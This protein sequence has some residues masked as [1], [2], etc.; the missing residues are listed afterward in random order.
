MSPVR[1]YLLWARPY[2]PM[3]GV[4]ITL[5]II[6]FVQPL[7]N[8]WLTKIIVDEV[9]KGA[10]SWGLYEVVTLMAVITVCGIAI[11]FIRG[12][13]TAGLGNR[14]MRDLRDQLYDHLQR[15]SVGF[16]EQRHVGG[17]SSRILHDIGGAQ[18]L[19]GGGVINLVMDLF[20]VLFAG[21]M[22]F[23][24]DATLAFIAL[25]ILPLYYLSFTNLNVRIRLAWRSVHRQMERISGTLV[26]RMS[27]I[28]VVQAFNGEKIEKHRFNKQTQQHFQHTMSAHLVSNLLGRMSETLANA[29]SIV[30]WLVG[31][32]FAL[33][34][35]MTAGEI[36]AFQM[37]LGNLYGPIQRFADVNVTIQNSVTNIERIFELFD[38][39]PDVQSSPDARPMPVCRGQVR[40]QDVS[41]KYV[42]RTPVPQHAVNWKDPD[43]VER[44]A[45][46]KKFF[47][48]PTNVNPPKPVIELEEREAMHDISFEA[49]PGQVIALVGP[50]GAGK[51][52]LI[53]FI[54][55]FYD[56]EKGR[57]FID[58]VDVRDYVLED[59]RRHIAIVLQDNILFSGSIRD[60]LVYGRPD[61]TAAEIVAAARSANAHEFIESFK[62][63]YDSI[64]GERGMRLSGGQKQRLAI[65]RA[66]LKD[67]QILIL[68]EATS[69][70]DSE[71]EA[72]VTE[73]L[74]RLM[75]GRTT[76]VIAHRLATVVRADQILVIDNG[77]IVQRG[78]HKQ[79]LREDGLYRKL[80]EQQLKAMKP[81]EM[82]DL[83]YGT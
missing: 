8:P 61:A 34:G 74:E 76:F 82:A 50:S 80:Y 4:I 55:R 6:Q 68:D 69:A 60:N 42:I 83:K 10:G 49:K 43:L 46:P 13:L 3:I 15:M 67:P 21:A 41:F 53:N 78:P 28:R 36:I 27:G 24:M 56:A 11:N 1:R 70:L 33:N 9:L 59:L 23:Q 26:E 72:L 71:S 18:N 29:G 81:E 65:A 47:W 48:L 51:S 22:L 79:L 2:W 7:A 52:T 75:E 31:G 73:A 39:Q 58:G 32:T 16:Y 38:E 62:D 57:V 77:R 14:M 20:L 44:E 66:L 63:G 25:S 37:L 30:I 45:T 35:K 5:G 64:I 19:I 40:F 17:L 12:Y 54:P